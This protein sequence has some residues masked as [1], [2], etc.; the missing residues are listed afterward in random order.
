MSHK[1]RIEAQ[2]FVDVLRYRAETTPERTA[3]TFLEDGEERAVTID[4]AALDRRVRAIAAML[5]DRGAA[6]ERVLLLLPQGL[7]FLI[8]FF[9]CLYA[10]ALAVPLAPISLSRSRRSLPRLRSVARSAEARFAFLA[11]A[12]LAAA[13][14]L[15]QDEEGLAGLELLAPDAVEDSGA[16]SWRPPI[17]ERGSTAFLQYTSGS[18]SE[19]KGVVVSHGNLLHNVEMLRLAARFTEDEVVVTWLPSFHDMGLIA[20]HLQSI[21]SGVPCVF[22]TPVHFL[23]KP[24]RWLAAI[25]RHRGTL[26]GGPNFAYELCL[27]RVGPEMRE[28]LD[29]GSWKTMFNGA[30][31][32]RAETQRR[33]AEVFGPCGVRAAAFF[34]CYGLAEATLLVTGRR[35]ETARRHRVR[36]AALREN[37]VEEAGPEE[38]DALVYVGCG[39]PSLGQRVAIVDPASGAERPPGH[40]GEI[41]VS[42]ASV[43]QGYWGHPEESAEVFRAHLAGGG[44]EPYLRTGDL[45]FLDGGDLFVTGRLKDMILIRGQ[46][47]YP[48]DIE[49]TVHGCHPIFVPAGAAAF[50]VEAEGEERLVLVQEVRRNAPFE[51]SAVVAEVSRRV[52]EEHQIELWALVL[53]PPGSLAKTTSGKVQRRACQESFRTDS[54]PALARW[55]RPPESAGGV[56]PRPTG[57][58]GEIQAWFV[59]RLARRLGVGPESLDPHQSFASHGIDSA[60]AVSLASELGERLGRDLPATLLYDHPTPAAVARFLAGESADAGVETAAAVERAG[61][62]IAIVGIGCRFPGARGPAAFWRLLHEGVDAISEVPAARWDL[63]SLFDA[64]PAAPGKMSTR[65]GGFLNAVDEFDAPHF[66][67]SPREAERM[68]PQ[69]RLL[70][71]VAWEA[72]EDAGLPPE[73]VRSSSTGVFVGLSNV[74]YARFQLGVPE[75]LDAYAG[76]GNAASIAANRLSFFFDFHGPSLTVDT[77]CSSAL[78]AV[79]LACQSLRTGECSLALA[80]GV[81]VIVDPGPTV[82]FSKAGLMAPDGRCK[83]FDARADGYVRS[84][85]CGVVVLKPLSRAE[86]DGDPVYAVILGSAVNQ[87]GRS[88]GLT[89]P[90]RQA[91]EAVLRAACRQAG[92]APG[93]VQY[94]ELHGTGTALGDPIEAMALG[95]VLAEERPPGQLCA[96]GSVKSNLGHLEAAAGAAGLIKVAL[97]LRQGEIPPSLHFAAPNPKIPFAELPLVVQTAPGPWPGGAGGERRLAGVS[98]FG[99]GGTNAHAILAGRPA[100]PSEPAEPSEPAATEGERWE[101]LPLSARTGEALDRAGAGLAAALAADP[102]LSLTDVAWTLQTGRARFAHRRVA[103]CR[104]REDAAG[105]ASAAPDPERIL[106]RRMGR[107]GREVAFL[108]PGLGDHYP[109]MAAGLYEAEPV[110]RAEVDRCSEILAPHLGLDLRARL[111]VS[112]G[113]AAAGSGTDLRRLLRRGGP[114]PAGDPLADTAVAQPA[115]FVIDW[116]LARLLA[117]WGIAPAALLGHSLGE[118]VAA[119]LSGVFSL[120]DA[121]VLVARR[122]RLIAALPAGAMLAVPLAEPAARELLGEDLSL[123]AVNGPGSCV[124]AG[125]VAAIEWLA[126][127]L[128][129][130]GGV[131]ARLR[132]SH[133]FH[134]RLMEPLRDAMTGL[135][136]GVERRAPR[137]PWLSNVTGGWITAEQ[138]GDPGYWADHLCGTVRF[139]EGVAELLREPERI[140]LEVGPGQTLGSFAQQHPG[141]AGE[142]GWSVLATLPPEHAR[143]PDAVFLRRAL[144]KLWLLGIE[145]DWAAVGSGRARRRISLPTYPFERQRHWLGT[146]PALKPSGPR[147][148]EGKRADPA[149]WFYRP[150]WRQAPP[151]PSQ[152]SLAGLAAGS[153]LILGEGRGLGEALR[154]ELTRMGVEVTAEP[155]VDAAAL[156]WLRADS[157]A[158]RPGP[159]HVLHLGG[160]SGPA[161]PRDAPEEGYESVVALVRALASRGPGRPVELAVVTDGLFRVDGGEVLFPE[162]ATVLGPSRVASQEHPEIHC[163]IID[164]SAVEVEAGGLAPALLAE[165]AARPAEGAESRV[166]LRGGARWIEEHEPLRLERPAAAAGLRSRGVYLLTGGLGGVGLAI[167]GALAREVQARLVL[168]GRSAFPAP[169][170]WRTWLDH[171]GPADRISRKILRLRELEGLGAEVL[172]LQADVA[173]PAALREAFQRTRERFGALHGVVHAAGSV[174][175]ATFRTLVETTAT[176]REAHFAPKVRGTL[177]LAAALGA[178]EPDF[179]LLVSSISTVLGGLGFTAYA[180][181][182]SF[183]DAFAESRRDG[184]WLSVAWDGWQVGEER[185][186]GGPGA[187]VAAYAM[188][189]EEGADAFLR[190]VGA[191]LSGRVVQS[192]G[193]LAARRAAWAYPWRA[194]P[195][196]AERETDALSVPARNE[197]ERR[198]AGLWRRALGVAEVGIHDNFFDLGGSSLIGV[199]LI[200]ELNRELGVNLANLALFES[201]TIAGLATTISSLGGPA[202]PARVSRAAVAPGWAGREVAIVGMAGRFPGL[203]S[204][205]EL[206]TALRDGVETISF[207]SDAELIAAGVDPE[208][209]RSPGYVRARPILRDVETFDAQFFGFSPREAALMDPQHRLFLES[210]WTALETAGYDARRFPGAVGLFAGCSLSSYLLSLYADP[211]IGPTLDPFQMVVGNDKDSMPT[212]VSYKLDLKGPSIA[213]QT[214]CSTSLVAVHLAVQSLRSGECDMALAGGVSVRVPQKFGYRYQEGGQDSPDGHCRAFDADSR[215][216]VFGDGVGVVVLKRLADAMADGDTIHAVIKG[217]AVNNDGALKAGYTA[218]S[219]EGQARAVERALKDAG[220]DPAT[221]TY[222]EAHGSGTR[223]GDPIEVAA[224]TKAYRSFTDA[225]GFCA[226]GSVK[227]NL[228]HLDRASGVTGLIKTVLALEH[229]T[230]P[231]TLHFRTPNP[232]IDFASSPF[233]VNAATRPWESSGGPLR[234][235]VNSLGM[236]GTN[237]HVVLE[238]APPAAASEPSRRP[239]QLLV[240]SAR[241]ATALDTA[242]ADLAAWLEASPE[243]NLADVAFTLQAGRRPFAHRRC[244]VVADARSAAEALRTRDARRVATDLCGESERPLAF[245]LPGVGDH[246]A[247]MG[248]ELYRLEPGF[249]RRADRCCELLRELLGLDLREV[250]FAAAEEPEP[251]AVRGE[252]L[253]LRRLLGRAGTERAPGPLDRTSVAQPAVFVVSWALAGLLGDWGLRPSALLGYSLGEY[254]AACLAGVFSLEDALALVAGRARLIEETAPGAMLAVPLSAADATPLLAEGVSLAAVNGQRLSVLSG[255]VAAVAAVERT[256]AAEGLACQRLPASHAFHS[257]LL[258]PIRERIAALFKGVPLA[259]PRIPLV[260]NVSGRWMTAAEATDPAYWADHACGTVH[261]ADGLRELAGLPGV[262]CLE[263]GPGQ[264]LASA[265]LQGWPAGTVPM[266]LPAMR[267]RHD[268][269]PESAVLLTAMGKLWAAGGEIDWNAFHQGER[270]RRLPLPTYPFERQRYWIDARRLSTSAGERSAVRAAPVPAVSKRPD[271]GSWFYTPAWRRSFLAPGGRSLAG[272]TWLLFDDGAGLGAA[273]SPRLRAAG[274]RVVRVRPGEAFTPAGDGSFL[275][276][277]GEPAAY[278]ELL[279]EVG[280]PQGI[281]HLWSAASGSAAA[282]DRVL[283]RGFYSLLFL[284]QALS[285][286]GAKGALRLIAGSANACEVIGGDLLAPA[287]ATLAGPVLVLPRE[288]SGVSCRWV[289]FDLRE[290][291]QAALTEAAGLLAAE[292]AGTDE[293]EGKVAFRGGYRWVEKFEPVLLP[294]PGGPPSRL[295]RRGVYLVTGGLGGLGLAVAEHLART[296]EARLV[297]LGRSA[298]APTA[299]QV[300]RIEAMEEAGSEILRLAADVTDRAALQAALARARERFG[301]IHGVFHT[302]GVPGEGLLQRKERSRAAAVLAPK[303]QGTA[304]LCE[305]LSDEP[306]DFMVLFSSSSSITGGLGEVDY[307]AANAFLDAWATTAGRRPF[308]VAVNWGPWEWDAWQESTLRAMPGLLDRVRRV[309]AE[310]GISF[311]EG[312][313]ALDRVLA[314]PLRQVAVLTPGLDGLRAQAAELTTASLAAFAPLPAA[315]RHSARPSLKN[316][317]VEPAGETEAKVAVVWAEMLGVDRIGR[318]DSF[319]D[320]GGHSLLATQVFARIRGLFGVELPLGVLFDG[321]TVA[322]LAVHI[323]AARATGAIGATG[324]NGEATAGAVAAPLP[325]STASEGPLTHAQRR[326]WFL[327]RLEPESPLHNESMGFRFQGRL[328]PGALAAAVSALVARHEVLRTSFDESAGEP[329]QRVHSALPVRLPVLDLGGLPEP[330]RTA[331]LAR[332]SREQARLPFDLGRAP[333]LRALLIRRNERRDERLEGEE[334]R[335]L[336]VIHHIVHDGWSGFLLQREITALY[337]AAVEGRNAALPPFAVRFLDFATW[338]RDWLQGEALET[339][340]G[341]AVR[342]LAGAP[343]VLRWQADRPRPARQTFRAAKRLF[344]L[345]KELVRAVAD[346]G[347]EAQASP[348]MALLAAFGVLLHFYTRQEDLL[349]ASPVANRTRVET[350]GVLGLFANLVVLRLDLAGDPAFPEILRRVRGATLS[351][352]AGQDLPFERLV[353]RLQV[354]RDPGHSLLVQAHFTLENEPLPAW[355]GAGITMVPEPFEHGTSPYEMDLNFVESD[356]GLS[357]ELVYS[358][359][360][361]DATTIDRAIVHFEAMMRSVATRPELRLSDLLQGFEKA[362]R[363]ARQQAARSLEGAS[364]EALRRLPRRQ[365]R[366]EVVSS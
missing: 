268:H 321:P 41:W 100:S 297:L 340:V 345:P 181:A 239:W 251:E 196:R 302:A 192:T 44:E 34:P 150:R 63:R 109:G 230:L 291:G 186:G 85:G 144:A 265:A 357:G 240:L 104:G 279:A 94:V 259:A 241:T 174:D 73:R 48:Q 242:S 286:E 364:L 271:V 360:L 182:N 339:R 256:L 139:G 261:F 115:V 214:H 123:A 45:G 200:A 328:S 83:V 198:L 212:T 210:A 19:P 300:A 191:E 128:A 98:S 363:G 275:L 78:V 5:V 74:D 353:E 81:N 276:P 117:S 107:A 4:H 137:V 76:T 318:H 190:L 193:D 317:Y 323:A 133:A 120:E 162:K 35:E 75:A 92:V 319:F 342:L 217:S 248:R 40:V 84:E 237:A 331:E 183:L 1:P 234:A 233:F 7:D 327:A 202:E 42:G 366:M 43:A 141:F 125:P 335:A 330:A 126:V 163:R 17:L 303:V 80:G 149:G 146:P 59:E 272:E 96:V 305:L 184:R 93:E 173:Q 207:F 167:A 152:P 311:A 252:G 320:L 86:A 151:V 225:R 47:H 170:E 290:G 312:M 12:Q 168:L 365:A 177:A 132:A 127:D 131:S 347:R 10:G 262:V 351:A 18:T 82:V 326:L 145:P 255:P 54:L 31:P 338:E 129:A 195:V 67:I 14:E 295:R 24:V 62:P 138:A 310:I 341:A 51:I 33:F 209:L 281:V 23:Q 361:F 254:V 313:E 77:A 325:R 102:D 249:R 346:H 101:L 135:V 228:G 188:T 187:S 71:E 224:L 176:D 58:A 65:W 222:V 8:A 219:V 304:L 283:D 257:T 46:N 153:W 185:P 172:V 197:L 119:A 278:R 329:L 206:W 116:A 39:G 308:T 108:L 247:G 154:R 343:T 298:A 105:L 140:L 359:D 61:E 60:S 245:L 56:A 87:D 334:W 11:A 159:R 156:A 49:W 203:E 314:A 70:L 350:E 226:L 66:G 246:F 50:S 267:H 223:L 114:A 344:A 296:V 273:L 95:A 309:R 180:A 178:A 121:L 91:Q 260:S 322:E 124:L 79:H 348:F 53:V 244:V 201:P 69:Q 299:G 208:L 130:G 337:A 112:A 111:V 356:A 274:A 158:G 324:A 221:L 38:T 16:G 143:Q 289:D 3:Y 362:E 155:R 352:L 57:G 243:A 90:S 227:T 30:E 88:N 238:Q 28:S 354:A 211:D 204:V 277:V 231:A 250:L 179:C 103:L 235:G 55:Q 220:V 166:A 134:S 89:A 266:A 148:E 13:R 64:D 15:L 229:R 2:S 205:S 161:G 113:P 171:H 269:Q 27:N 194:V 263:V 236:G 293:T 287:Q 258:E 147:P 122:A 9:G 216:T 189:T 26:S 288:V 306:V 6:G 72:L 218:P 332:V 294:A 25:S 349:V 52:V 355:R 333:L 315:G 282:L 284:G 285:G 20:T 136:A 36:A 199:Q 280:R 37:L 118:Y 21:Y 97:A 270:R 336:F 175:P 215:G 264:A 160:V 99:F 213:V 110:F 165:L 106:A 68:D 253:D 157:A 301:A 232:E 142:P 164:L 307:S 29:L 22:M 32:I 358:P 169:D 292:I 316:P